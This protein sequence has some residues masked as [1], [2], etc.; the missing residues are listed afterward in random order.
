[1]GRGDI[2]ILD[3][4]ENDLFDS[5]VNVKRE[6]SYV[7]SLLFWY[8]STV[9]KYKHCVAHFHLKYVQLRVIDIGYNGTGQN[10]VRT[11]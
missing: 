11:K 1:M 9:S 6:F 4:D 5:T 2:L 10:S 3:Y 8:S 7:I